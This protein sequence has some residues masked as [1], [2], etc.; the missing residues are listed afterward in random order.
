M[1]APLRRLATF[2]EGDLAVALFQYACVMLI[3][4]AICGS[5]ILGARR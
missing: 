5:V 1:R 2:A 3:V 4:A